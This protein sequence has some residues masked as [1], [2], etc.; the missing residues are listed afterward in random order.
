[1]SLHYYETQLTGQHGKPHPCQVAY[2]GFTER[3]A[4]VWLIASGHRRSVVELLDDG[5]LAELE[6]LTAADHDYKYGRL[7][8]PGEVDESELEPEQPELES[9]DLDLPDDEPAITE[10]EARELLE[11]ETDEPEL[12]EEESEEPETEVSDAA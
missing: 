6:V 3:I 7:E 12:E 2:D 9:D 5:Q 11:S 1:M 8:E 10:E 4:D